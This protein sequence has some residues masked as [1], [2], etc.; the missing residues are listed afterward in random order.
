[1]WDFF[2]FHMVNR[3]TFGYILK[4]EWFLGECMP[5]LCALKQGSISMINSRPLLLV[6]KGFQG[7]EHPHILDTHPPLQE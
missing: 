1:M 3:D 2:F 7:L 6:N 5:E 4:F